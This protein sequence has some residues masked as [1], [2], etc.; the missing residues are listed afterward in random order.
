MNKLQEIFE[1]KRQEVEA[2]KRIVPVSDY[3]DLVGQLE[4][5]KGFLNALTNSTHSVSLIAE[6]KKAS[7]S[8]GVIRENFFPGEIA[9]AYR[10]AGADCLSVLTDEKY[11]GGHMRNV[12][13]AKEVSG[14]PVLRKDFIFDSYQLYEARAWGADAILLIVA[15]LEPTQLKELHKEAEEIGLDVLVEVHSESEADIALSIH[16]DLVG[17]NNRDLS[18]FQ[19]D[20]SI[21]E[22]I[23]PLLREQCHIVSESALAS[24]DDVKR[25]QWAG[26]KS[27][28][29]GTAFC[30]ALDVEGKVREVM[31]WL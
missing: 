25:V 5:S 6:V 8:A 30:S 31:D 18:T 17:I 14:L 9:R 19:T 3:L 26:A 1:W 20:L 15:M 11:F 7:P 23:G 29:I 21:T 2:A 28:L 24:A 13:M 27:V 10:M 16:A 12:P 22:R 4:P